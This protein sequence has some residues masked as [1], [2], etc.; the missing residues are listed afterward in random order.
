M[1]PGPGAL[2]LLLR[3]L[4]ARHRRLVHR[5]HLRRGPPGQAAVPGAQRRAPA[6]AHHRPAGH[7]AARGHGEGAQRE[8]AA[9]FAQHA[10]QGARA[11]RAPVPQAPTLRRCGCCAR[12]LAFDPA[13]RPTAEEALADPYFAGLASPAREPA[14]APVSKLAFEF[15]RRKLA[16]DDVRELIYREILEYHPQMLAEHLA[17]N[18]GRQANFLYPSAVDNFKRQFA[19]AEG[20]GGGGVPGTGGG[21][22]GWE[23]E[24]EVERMEEEAQEGGEGPFSGLGGSGRRRSLPR[25]RVRE[26]QSEAARATTTPP[27]AAA[28]RW[29]QQHPAAAACSSSRWQPCCRCCR[30]CS[31]CRCCRG[32]GSCRRRRALEDDGRI[33]G[34]DPEGGAR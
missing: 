34:P 15:E 7:A 2:R 29:Q 20:V 1:V 19:A 24:A 5:L 11:V 25:E 13:A 21:A 23:G 8:G 31:C 16:P 4:L 32:R 30:C 27:N 26:F 28:S 3:P 22:G 33:C 14:A 10:A 6:R 18:Q 17:G 9:L 12:L